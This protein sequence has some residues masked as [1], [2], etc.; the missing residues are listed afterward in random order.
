MTELEQLRADIVE[1]FNNIVI[2][3]NEEP[4]A[5]I[6]T[7]YGSGIDYIQKMYDEQKLEYCASYE[8]IVEHPGKVEKINQAIQI[9]LN[10]IATLYDGAATITSIR[11]SHRS[12]NMESSPILQDELKK[13]NELFYSNLSRFIVT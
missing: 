1:N 4:F 6:L 12:S 13:I 10:N 8:E 9:C 2:T 7:K 3:M 11:S 5:Q